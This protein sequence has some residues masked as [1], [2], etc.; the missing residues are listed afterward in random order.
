[1]LTIKP[2][3]KA[4]FTIYANPCF[5]ALSPGYEEVFCLSEHSLIA[6]KDQESCCIW[7]NIIYS[8]NGLNILK[9]IEST[10][11]ISYHFYTLSVSPILAPNSPIFGLVWPCGHFFGL[12]VFIFSVIWIRPNV[13]ARNKI[14][15]TFL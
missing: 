12:M 14:Q 2:N 1:M 4:E 6:M 15:N 13:P 8:S 11:Y 10:D 3:Q 5:R 7:Y 9:L